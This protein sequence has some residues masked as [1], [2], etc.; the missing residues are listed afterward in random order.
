MKPWRLGKDWR[1]Q[2]PDTGLPSEP[3]LLPSWTQSCSPLTQL[4]AL[5]RFLN[6]GVSTY[7]RVWVFSV[8][9]VLAFLY[10]QPDVLTLR[11]FIAFIVSSNYTNAKSLFPALTFVLRR[12]TEC[13]VFCWGSFILLIQKLPKGLM[14]FI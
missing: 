5:S 2:S 13:N 6:G 8:V 4:A 10:V 9:L 11:F 3:F 14:A 12:H 1:T 7:P